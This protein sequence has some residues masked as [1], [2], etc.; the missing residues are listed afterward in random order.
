MCS[1]WESSVSTTKF[2]GVSGWLISV[3]PSMVSNLFSFFNFESSL[4][5]LLL[6]ER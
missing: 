4:K 3:S 1:P 5:I 6:S 2:S